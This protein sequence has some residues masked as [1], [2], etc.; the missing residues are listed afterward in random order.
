MKIYKKPETSKDIAKNARPSF[1]IAEHALGLKGDPNKAFK[2]VDDED[3]RGLYEILIELMSDNEWHT[4]R[5]LSDKTGSTL[6]TASA[7]LLKLYRDKTLER[8]D[9][10]FCN[11]ARIAYR[12]LS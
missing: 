7:Y 5:E 6:Q 3:T 2:P 4:A 1:S 8:K 9:G 10:R 11:G 12:A